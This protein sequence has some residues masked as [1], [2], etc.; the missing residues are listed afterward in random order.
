[1]VAVVVAP[2]PAGL[3]LN[4]P[5]PPAVDVVPKAGVVVLQKE[6]NSDYGLLK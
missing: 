1:V 2:N 3:L 5:V 6:E 4:N